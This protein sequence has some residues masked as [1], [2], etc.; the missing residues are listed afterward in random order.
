ME[1][2]I[3]NFFQGYLFSSQVSQVRHPVYAGTLKDD[4]RRNNKR[5]VNKKSA[6]PTYLHYL[7]TK[8]IDRTMN[9]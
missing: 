7:H 6:A 4:P 8:K 9:D 3:I 2:W 1:L 5:V